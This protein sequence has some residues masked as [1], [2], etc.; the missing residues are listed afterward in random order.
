MLINLIPTRFVTPF[1]IQF[2]GETYCSLTL[3]FPNCVEDIKMSVLPSQR[4]AL[5]EFETF[6]SLPGT[7]NQTF[8]QRRNLSFS[9]NAIAPLHLVA[10]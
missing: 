9:K 4:E 8:D 5:L 6:S 3:V 7:T 1:K 10:R 2:K